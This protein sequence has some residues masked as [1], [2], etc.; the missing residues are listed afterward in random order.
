MAMRELGPVVTELRRTI[1]HLQWRPKS[2]GVWEDLVPLVD[3]LGHN[4]EMREG[5]YC[6]EWRIADKSPP[7]TWEMLFDFSSIQGDQGDKGDP[8]ADSVLH[9]VT[10][11]THIV[12]A[13]SYIT[14]TVSGPD[15]AKK[16]HFD[17]YLEDVTHA[18]N[19]H[20]N[21]PSA[22]PDIIEFIITEIARA[23]ST[24]EWSRGILYLKK[25]N[26]EVSSFVNIGAS[27]INITGVWTVPTPS[28]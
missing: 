9:S 11:D 5:D 10:Y 25:P 1:T 28:E 15:T 6:I 17:F 22:H 19:V 7:D 20:N 3:L 16:L 12:F 21:D 18:I 14:V 2:T 4:I 24:L 13:P 8:G 27:S 23:G 26:G